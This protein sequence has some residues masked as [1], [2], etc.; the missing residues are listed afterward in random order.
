MAASFVSRRRRATKAPNA[1][2]K[3]APTTPTAIPAFAP[4]E[5]P[6]PPPTP[7][8]G[9]G[10][11]GGDVDDGA[12]EDVGAAWSVIDSVVPRVLIFDEVGGTLVVFGGVGIA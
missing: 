2:A 12:A 4:V 8:F 9:S 10:V 3:K 7:E 6:S 11:G 1:P 5:S